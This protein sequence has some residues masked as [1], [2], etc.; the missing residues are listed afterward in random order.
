MLCTAYGEVLDRA[1]RIVTTE[2]RARGS[3]EAMDELLDTLENLS[4]ERHFLLLYDLF[5]GA[6]RLTLIDGDRSEIMSALMLRLLPPTDWED[7]SPGGPL[8]HLLRLLAFRQRSWL[9]GSQ[10]GFV[11]AADL[12]AR[13]PRYDDVKAELDLEKEQSGGGMQ[14]MIKDAFTGE[15]EAGKR[16]VGR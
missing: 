15:T 14:Q 2:L 5:T 13:M 16:L 12:L 10:E 3:Q 8:V 1:A 11:A 4:I 7:S 9:A 6:L